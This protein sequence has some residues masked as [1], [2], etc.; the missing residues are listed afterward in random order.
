MGREERRGGCT[1][2]D[3]VQPAL[4][5]PLEER[6]VPMIA[7]AVTFNGAWLGSLVEAPTPG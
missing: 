7:G 4:H 2:G 1:V 3:V 6:C 5:P